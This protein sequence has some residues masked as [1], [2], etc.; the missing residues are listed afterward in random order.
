VNDHLSK[1]SLL[2]L[3]SKYQSLG[4]KLFQVFR[5]PMTHNSQN[6][7]HSPNK[8]MKSHTKNLM[9]YLTGIDIFISISLN[10]QNMH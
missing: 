2:A 8:L 5:E 9:I 4:L 3:I 10:N 6:G 7:D 1:T